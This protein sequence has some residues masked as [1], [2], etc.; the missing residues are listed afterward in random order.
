MMR[1]I[2][3]TLLLLAVTMAWA[4]QG[5]APAE[6]KGAQLKSDNNFTPEQVQAAKEGMSKKAADGN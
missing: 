2:R 1:T 4:C 3:W 5:S 6:E